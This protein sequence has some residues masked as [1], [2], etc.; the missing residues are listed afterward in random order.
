MIAIRE[1]GSWIAFVDTWPQHTPHGKKNSRCG[2]IHSF[3]APSTRRSQ[4]TAPLMVAQAAAAQLAIQEGGNRALKR[5]LGVK[6]TRK[7]K[8][9]PSSP[10]P[11]PN[12][13]NGGQCAAELERI[14]ALERL[15]RQLQ[16]PKSAVKM[17]KPGLRPALT[18]RQVREK[19][20]LEMEVLRRQLDTPLG[21]TLV[22]SQGAAPP[23]RGAPPPSP[24][25]PPPPPRAG[26]P[27]PPPPPRKPAA[28]PAH[29]AP[30]QAARF[31]NVLQELKRKQASRKQPNINWNSM[32]KKS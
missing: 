7:K 25:P 28:A 8:N 31:N 10:L 13:T 6:S 1:G 5:I 11:P 21:G 16:K 19:H 9:T 20:R 17:R 18:K 15:V 22:V 24:P 3:M 26:A 2:G 30:A 4:R 29:A 32:F 14:K 12:A 23:P 27:P